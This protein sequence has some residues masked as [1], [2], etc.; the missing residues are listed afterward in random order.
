MS[1]SLTFVLNV[2]LTS[3]LLTF[4]AWLSGRSPQL[5]GFI[6]AL[7]L[8]TMIVL[9]LSHARYGQTEAPMALAKSILFALP[10]SLLFLVPFLLAPRFGWS[11]W[12][13]YLIGAVALAVGYAIHRLVMGG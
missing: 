8:S 12:Q 9:P 3:S 6:V 11:F 1:N 2:V 7:P 10:I 4:A 5:A 13:T